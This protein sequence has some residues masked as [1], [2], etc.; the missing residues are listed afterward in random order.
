MSKVVKPKFDKRYLSF[1]TI[2]GGR[3]PFGRWRG[4]VDYLFVM[5]WGNKNNPMGLDNSDKRTWMGFIGID[6][7]NDIPT[8][9]YT[10]MKQ[11]YRGRGI[12]MYMYE[13]CINTFGKLSTSYNG[14]N[15][16]ISEDAV[17]IWDKLIDTHYTKKP[18]KMG[19][20]VY[21]RKKNIKR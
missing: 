4:D 5:R 17:K 6:S 20:I 8:V 15:G 14:R 16:C 3:L 11:Q 12:G 19:Y 10:Y 18:K 21:P 1:T 2:E 13:R 9:S 7:I